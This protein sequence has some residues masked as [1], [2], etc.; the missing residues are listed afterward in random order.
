MS[1]E[2]VYVG[3]LSAY[4]VLR[5]L[6][7]FNHGTTRFTERKAKTKG[8]ALARG[9]TPGSPAAECLLSAQIQEGP[10][11]SSSQGCSESCRAGPE[12]QYADAR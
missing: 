9:H 1:F 6:Q 11:G 5:A 2:S 4:T 7:I 8:K 10:V 3:L 12:S